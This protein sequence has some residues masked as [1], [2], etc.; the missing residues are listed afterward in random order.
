M[1]P[2]MLLII[3]LSIST[4]VAGVV[5]FVIQLREVKKAASKMKNFNFDSPA[6]PPR[7]TP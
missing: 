5:G 1:D 3:A 7:A 4:P 2:Q 6:M